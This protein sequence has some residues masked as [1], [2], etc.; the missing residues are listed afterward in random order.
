M[1]LEL[2]DDKLN[3]ILE[4]GG[5]TVLDFYAPWCGPCKTYSPILDAFQADN[6]DIIVVKANVDLNSETASKYGIR[7][8]PTTVLFKDGRMVT[9]VPGV[10]QKDKLEEF[11]SNLR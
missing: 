5:V 1:I 11:V 2:K 3:E 4:K 6:E 7:S 9:K 10:V 8:I